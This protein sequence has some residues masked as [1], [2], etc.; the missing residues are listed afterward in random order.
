MKYLI[1]VIV[2]TLYSM[3]YV[4]EKNVY[5]HYD[6]TATATMTTTTERKTTTTAPLRTRTKLSAFKNQRSRSA[7]RI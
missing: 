3:E 7:H 1:I 4:L 6:T 5:N 2:L